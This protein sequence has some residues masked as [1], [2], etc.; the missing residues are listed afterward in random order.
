VDGRLEESSWASAPI[1]TGFTRYE[2]SEGVPALEETEVR[3]LFGPDAVYFGVVA[4]DSEPDRIRASLTERDNGVT[5]DDWVRIT[6]DTFND[7]SQAYVFYVNPRG[8]QADGLWVEGAQRRH[9]PPVDFAPDFLWESAGRVTDTG[10]QAEVRIPYVS[11]RFRDAEVQ[12]WG[13]N[14][15]REIHRAEYKS[16][17][18]PLTADAANPLELSGRLVG[19]RG[20]EP[21]RLVELN[22][23]ATGKRTGERTGGAFVR[24]DF[25]P[26][27]G[28][29]ARYGLT[30]NL[31]LDA[32]VNPD[33]SQVEADAGQVAVN[34]RFAL[35]FPEKRPF[36][37]EGTEIFNTPRRLVYTRAVVD[38]VG[39]AKL[40]GK[41]G[42]FNVG[43]LGAVDESPITFGAAD[44]R[45]LFNLVR[46][47]RDLGRGSTAGILYTDRTLTGGMSYNRVGSLDARIVLGQRYT[48][49]A[50]VAGA[51]SREPSDHGGGSRDLFGPLLSTRI[52]RSGQVFSWNAA[53]EDVHPEFR[54][55]SGFIR[56]IDVTHVRG[57]VQY[58]FLNEPGSWL[59]DWGPQFEV[60][61]F[62]DHDE[63]WA[64]E[65]FEEAEL[66]AG[67]DVS[68]RGPNG[69]N[70]AVTDGYFSFDPEDYEAYRVATPQGTEAFQVPDHL[71][72][73]LGARLWGRTRPVP[74]LSL[75]GLIRYGEVPI[76]AEASRG[77][78]L[79]LRPSLDV[80]LPSGLLAELSVT[81]SRIDRSEGGRFSVAQIPRG[82]LQYQ[83][84]KA[85][86]VRAIAQYNL[87]QRDALRSVGGVPLVLDE[88]ASESLDEGELQYDL[89]ISYEPSPG[90][91]VYAG[92]SRVREGP[93]TYR[94]GE[95]EPVA[96]G[97]FVKVSYLFRL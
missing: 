19:I 43:Y 29:N 91:I 1:L 2:P 95:L 87:Q 86:F 7:N 38:P 81:Y 72:H 41:L 36:F 53:L 84:T 90:T 39:G 64:G 30:P 25:E 77:V 82:K 76:Y 28:L 46:L 3:V 85:F 42:A 22:P 45:A 55:R 4:H 56:R 40:T 88:A 97:L 58:T 8:I 71:E 21:R 93:D 37:L 31:V 32:T 15:I 6:L 94:F 47:R 62:Y 68:L 63:F 78:E 70:L 27:F 92:W 49:T 61:A 65:Q 80:R 11:L 26:A 96:E 54:A 33:F 23:V 79:Q 24:D 20:L 89:L 18:A 57:Q 73:L 59:E 10:W 34:E 51:W 50:Q 52:S 35:F 67:I 5:D 13:L 83:F 14:V 9:G 12:T 44:E 17:W 16:S 48:L 66:Q 60:R 75:N 69:F 74:W